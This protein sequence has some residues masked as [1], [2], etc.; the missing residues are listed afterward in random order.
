MSKE[1]QCQRMSWRTF[2]SGAAT[3]DPRKLLPTQLIQLLGLNG[4]N[5]NRVNIAL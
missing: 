3:K 1:H 4:D 5:S 2:A